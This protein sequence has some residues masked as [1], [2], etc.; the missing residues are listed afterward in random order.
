VATPPAAA[1]PAATPA[2]PAATPDQQAAAQ[3]PETLKDFLSSVFSGLKK[4]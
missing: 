4:I 3:S 1:A 2:A